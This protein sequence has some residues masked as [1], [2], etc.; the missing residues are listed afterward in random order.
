MDVSF[1]GS[2]GTA[3][4]EHV[5]KVL[6]PAILAHSIRVWLIADHAVGRLS[7]LS[8][9]EREAL[10]V[11]C[12]FHDAGTATI[13][14]GPQRFEV[15]G[16][17]AASGFLAERDVAPELRRQVWEAI[18]LHTSPGIAERMGPLTRFVRLGVTVDFGSDTGA[19]SEDLRA[20]LGQFPRADIEVVLGDAV[21]AQAV[22]RPNKAPASSWPGGLLVA[23]LADPGH[24][25]VNEA[26]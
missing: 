22:R 5:R 13:Y 17:D 6:H 15:E 21:V 3:A 9:E 25:G 16:A 23:H 7:P 2:L 26:F 20:A 14:D 19:I 4:F 10:A 18:A 12:L 24:T 8:A 1:G 11:A